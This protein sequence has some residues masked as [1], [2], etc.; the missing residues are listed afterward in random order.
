[1]N[2][3]SAG[4]TYI[5]LREETERLKL[6]LEY[7]RL[8]YGENLNYNIEID[9]NINPENLEIPNM[10]LQ[11]FVENSIWHGFQNKEKEG[12]IE[13][14]ISKKQK[15]VQD[16]KYQVVEINIKD[17]GVGLEEGKKQK[18]SDHISK[19]VSIIKERLALLK[20]EISGNDFIKVEDRTDGIQG[21]EVNITLLPG[22][23]NEI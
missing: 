1:M 7:E 22:Q 21:V 20:P 13:I 15:A 3:D 11:P 4:N 16:I 14:V 8:R 18:K 23:Y 19:G 2:L 6:Y 12:K 17:N 9:P 5:M 10:I